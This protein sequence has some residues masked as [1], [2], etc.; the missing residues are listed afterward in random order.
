MTPDTTLSLRRLDSRLPRILFAAAVLL[1]AA[2]LLAAF[3]PAPAELT[4]TLRWVG[5][6]LFIPLVA[7]RRS[8][9]AWT[10]FA[11]LAGAELG[12][13]APQFAAQTHFLADIF[14]RLIRM[15]V[16]P[17]IFG[18]IVTGIAG[19]GKLGGVGRVALK[20]IVVF[21]G[22][23]TLGLI[24]GAVAIN[25]SQAG[26]GVTLPASV[27][28]VIPAAHPSGWQEILLNIFPENI[29]QAVAQNQILQ[30]AIFAL[31]F[32]TAMAT[33]PEPKRAPL[34]AVLQSL[35]ETMFRMTRII[36]YMAPVAAGAALAYTVGSMG[37]M[38]LLPLARLAVTCY[39]TLI[40]FALLVLAPILLLFRVPLRRFAVAVAEPAALGFATTSSEVAL[41]LAM[42]RMEEFGVPRWI[43]SFVI[44]TGY[45]FNMTGSSI[46]V[47]MAALF[48]AQ[49]AGI[50]LSV[51]QQIVLL[52]TL[53][54]T[55]KGIAGVPRATLIVLLAV[56]GSFH[57]PAAAVL[58]L[59]G[60]D[61]LMDMGRT[62]MNVIGNC[63]AAAVVAQWEGEL[64]TVPVAAQ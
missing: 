37:L 18:G 55:S 42:E 5:L 26:V 53:V 38:T 1:F 2:G 25:F 7:Q 34:L 12:V 33:L 22:A 10:F 48:A 49:A 24:L 45:S 54:L 32:G 23:T 62:G 17:L 21:E 63:M 29:A 19:H 51:V 61:T 50:H 15:I 9:L 46:Y 6:G 30:V 35:T 27:Q 3:F 14:L 39:A 59:L 11:M 16:A 56:A 58:M 60:V 57:I 13:D 40:V 20:S 41:P 4:V 8:L 36:M 47:S 44:P 64:R 28:A 52:A 43:V 31:L